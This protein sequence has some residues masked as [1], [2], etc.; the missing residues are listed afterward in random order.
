MSAI[1]VCLYVKGLSSLLIITMAESERP[2]SVTVR[3]R[4]WLNEN[5]WR[6]RQYWDSRL[7]ARVAKHLNSVAILF[8]D[9]ASCWCALLTLATMGYHVALIELP[10]VLS[11]TQ[12]ERA[13]YI[14]NGLYPATYKHR[15]LIAGPQPRD[16]DGNVAHRLIAA[17]FNN[18]VRKVW[19]ADPCVPPYPSIRNTDLASVY[20]V[21]LAVPWTSEDWARMCEQHWIPEAVYKSVRRCTRFGCALTCSQCVAPWRPLRFGATGLGRVVKIAHGKETPRSFLDDPDSDDDCME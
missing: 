8:S 2:V 13:L 3:H 17:A 15:S 16:T 4:Y 6:V 11:E 10:G 18:G 21:C 20:E 19:L 7:R 9:S 1:F 12:H 14:H 5:R